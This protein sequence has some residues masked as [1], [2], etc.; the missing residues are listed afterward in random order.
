M[1]Q[2]AVGLSLVAFVV[3]AMVVVV[4]PKSI[5]EPT[6]NPAVMASVVPIANKTVDSRI[7]LQRRSQEV[8]YPEAQFDRVPR[9]IRAEAT[10]YLK[11]LGWKPTNTVGKIQVGQRPRAT[12]SRGTILTVQDG[13]TG[14]PDGEM[15]IWD[16]DDSNPETTEGEVYWYDYAR[17]E[18]MLVYVQYDIHD[19]YD[20]I[21]LAG[22]AMWADNDEVGYD[23]VRFNRMRRGGSIVP[24]SLRM[25]STCCLNR[26][27]VNTVQVQCFGEGTAAVTKNSWLAASI[28]AGLGFTWGAIK[29]AASGGL[30]TSLARGFVEAVEGGSMSALGNMI[31]NFIQRGSSGHVDCSREASVRRWCQA[32]RPDARTMIWGFMPGEEPT[33]CY[34]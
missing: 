19:T 17:G 21:P 34:Q 24:A 11:S 3:A 26:D 7:K 8:P 2:L 16:W 10:K 20:P 6:G 15:V 9:H 14:S 22:G 29:G 23:S 28:G 32:N 5:S 12:A 33:Q 1:K 31:A 18:E 13:S 4:P 30:G 27:Q 25:L